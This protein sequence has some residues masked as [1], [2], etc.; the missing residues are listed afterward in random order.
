MPFYLRHRDGQ[1]DG[2]YPDRE[3]AIEA[4]ADWPYAPD[5]VEA[6]DHDAASEAALIPYDWPSA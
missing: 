1:T 5:L 3:S 6:A 4:S 2:P